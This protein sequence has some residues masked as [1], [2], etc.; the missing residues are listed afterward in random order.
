MSFLTQLPWVLGWIVILIVQ[1]MNL[2]KGKGFISLLCVWI[3]LVL[4]VAWDPAVNLLMGDAAASMHFGS[5]FWILFI[6]TAVIHVLNMRKQKRGMQKPP[7]PEEPKESQ[8]PRGRSLAVFLWEQ[9]H[10]SF[11]LLPGQLLDLPLPPHGF[12][13]G[14]EGLMVGQR[15][16][17][18]GTGVLG[19]SA[20]VVG[21]QP[22]VQIVG[23]AGIEGAVAAAQNV[24]VVHLAR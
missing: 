4:S 19:G 13:L 12:L 1:D 11:F 22:L 23:P 17:P 5:R 16:R 10:E 20:C 9:P 7:Q 8:N 24:G 2:K 6:L 14:V 3:S 21:G 15:D 18:P